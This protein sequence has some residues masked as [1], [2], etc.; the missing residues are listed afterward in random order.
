MPSNA[1]HT[2]GTQL[3]AEQMNARTKGDEAFSA[4][5]EPTSSASAMRLAAETTLPLSNNSLRDMWY[6]LFS[7]S[8][9]LV[10]LTTALRYEA[11]QKLSL[12]FAR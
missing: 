5:G 3:V 7:H 11:E 10:I 4:K 1:W 12:P 6:K 8:P 9:S 2:A